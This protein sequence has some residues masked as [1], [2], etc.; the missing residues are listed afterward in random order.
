VQ[1]QNA[2]QLLAKQTPGQ[3]AFRFKKLMVLEANSK[4]LNQITQKAA[5]TRHHA[6]WTAWDFLNFFYS[7][8]YFSPVRLLISLFCTVHLP[9]YSKTPSL[10]LAIRPVVIRRSTTQTS[11]R[12][13]PCPL[14]TILAKDLIQQA[15]PDEASFWTGKACCA[16]LF[17]HCVWVTR[18]FEHSRKLADVR[19]HYV[20][21]CIAN[22]TA[23]SALL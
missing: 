23:K 3:H 20:A 19:I 22:V 5:N 11:R 1:F 4:P 17:D 16:N 13:S 6:G 14:N 10:V 15:F 7:T 8:A 12:P 18:K 2:I 21:V 9:G